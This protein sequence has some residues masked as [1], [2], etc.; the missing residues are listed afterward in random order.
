M[1]WETKLPNQLCQWLKER[2]IP[3][4][5]GWTGVERNAMSAPAVLVTVKE[6]H[7]CSAGFEDYL[8]EQYNEE[9]GIW[10][11]LYGKKVEVTLGLDLYAPER[12]S[13]QSLQT[14]LE[15]LIS[16]LTLEAPDGLQVGNITC[17]QT[18]WDEG[19]R[20]IKRE[21]SARCTLWL[22]AVCSEG[23]EFLDFELRGGWK[24]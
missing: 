18:K 5:T 14:L 20:R 1:S 12:E 2:E 22:R 19:Q 9:K 17:G 13:E 10:E 11:E 23:T 15:R 6:Y 3:A 16:L 8:G 7:A 24:N 4:L 21:V